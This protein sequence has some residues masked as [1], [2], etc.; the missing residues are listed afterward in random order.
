MKLNATS[1]LRRTLLVMAAASLLVAA[2]TSSGQSSATPSPPRSRTPSLTATATALPLVLPRPTDIPTD[3][4]CE[5]GHSC[6]GILTVGTHH[7]QVFEPGF[8]FEMPVTGWENIA[9]E[10]GVFQLLP[11]DSPGDAIAFFREPRATDE[12]GGPV[13]GVGSTVPELTSWLRSNQLLTV[14]APFHTAVGRHDA[15]RMDIAI[16]PGAQAHQS[17]CP[18]Q[19]CVR[20]FKGIDPSRLPAWEWDWGSA[21]TEHQRLYLLSVKGGVLAIF[22]DSLDGTTFD[23]LNRT[24]ETVLKSVHFDPGS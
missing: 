11:I 1:R 17:D 18:V 16:A 2:C 12:N 10:G 23:A 4:T 14:S 19:V 15:V 8:S 3:G 24:A 20:F 21:G 6:L 22:V 13:A 7:T 9:Q 5:A